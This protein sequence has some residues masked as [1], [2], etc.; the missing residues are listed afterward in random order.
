MKVITIDRVDYIGGLVLSLLFS[1]GK[2][3]LSTLVVFSK[4]IHIHSMTNIPKFRN[5]KSIG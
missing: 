5:S 1:D 2:L 4:D 3:K